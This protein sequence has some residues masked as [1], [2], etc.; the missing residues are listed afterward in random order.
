MTKTLT[1]NDEIFDRYPYTCIGVIVA[2][3]ID[4]S[5]N[6]DPEMGLIKTA[7]E[8]VVEKFRDIEICDEPTLKAW[9]RVYK[10]MDAKKYKCSAES[11]VKR[12]LTG[13]NLNS[14]NSLV[15][16]YNYI[17]LKYTLPVGGESLDVVEGDIIL[18]E[19]TGDER[20]IPLFGTE[21]EP[22][23]PCEIIYRDDNDV[24]C[25]RWNWREAEKTKLT[26]ETTSA[27]LEIEG[28]IAEDVPRI[29][30]ATAEMAELIMKFCGGEVKTYILDKDNK[31]VEIA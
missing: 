28:I 2:T 7:E 14:I 22:P 29:E 9:R 5:K 23:K 1:I 25:R 19:A 21:N 4:N 6:Q 24:M 12:T 18:C 16:L 27:V 11:L 10:D 26:D 20:F 3:G 8:L 31:S 30:V 15:N 17:S 13:A